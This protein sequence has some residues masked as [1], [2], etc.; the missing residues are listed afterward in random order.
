MQ[1]QTQAGIEI[2]D[3]KEP[4]DI[5]GLGVEEILGQ[6]GKEHFQTVVFWWWGVRKFQQVNFTKISDGE[7]LNSTFFSIWGISESVKL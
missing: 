4:L 1:T 7:E 6:G 3:F 5:L 2:N